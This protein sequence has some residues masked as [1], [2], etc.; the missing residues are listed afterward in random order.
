MF[1]RA[2]FVLLSTS[3]IDPPKTIWYNVV[4]HYTSADLQSDQREDY[5]Y[6]KSCASPGGNMSN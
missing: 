3:H 2:F 5:F 6:G 1:I 4:R